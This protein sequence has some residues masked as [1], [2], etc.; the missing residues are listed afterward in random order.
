MTNVLFKNLM[1]I[2]GITFASFQIQAATAT[3]TVSANIVPISSLVMSGSIVLGENIDNYQGITQIKAN[4]ASIETSAFNTKNAARLKINSS[5]NTLYEISISPSSP[6]IDNASNKMEFKTLRTRNDFETLNN[7]KE[8][9][10]VIEAVM[11]DS[12]TQ[13]SGVYF[14][15]VEINVNYN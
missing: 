13:D 12:A 15:T 3:T 2:T 7:N 10:L 14:G 1:L 5:N 9:E 4:G 11:K 6:V 8:Q